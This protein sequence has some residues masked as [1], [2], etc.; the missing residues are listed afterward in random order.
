MNET[1]YSKI[2]WG[3]R[4]V[5]PDDVLA[6]ESF[7]QAAE[8]AERINQM[9]VDFAQGGCCTKY[10]PVIYANVIEWPEGTPHDPD[11]TVLDDYLPPDS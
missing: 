2:K 5:G 4:V 8:V 10:H 1:P 9:M 3:V 11:N 6:T 7:E